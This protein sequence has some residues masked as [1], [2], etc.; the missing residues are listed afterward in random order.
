MGKKDES[1]VTDYATVYKHFF[2]RE[3]WRVFGARG[4][5]LHL[6]RGRPGPAGWPREHTAF[7]CTGGSPISSSIKCVSF[8]TARGT[9]MTLPA[10]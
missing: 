1:N 6:Q 9:A 7:I 5:A 3:L 10:G 4:Y 2:R 8:D